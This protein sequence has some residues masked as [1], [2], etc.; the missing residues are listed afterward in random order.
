MIGLY[1][2]ELVY[3]IDPNNII[4]LFNSHGYFKM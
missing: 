3:D 4:Q 2:V 1:I